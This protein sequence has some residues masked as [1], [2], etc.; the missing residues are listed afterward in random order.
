MNVG[1]S[2]SKLVGCNFFVFYE[3]LL[4]FCM[5]VFDVLVKLFSVGGC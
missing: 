1:F 3:G 4:Q 2:L 5:F